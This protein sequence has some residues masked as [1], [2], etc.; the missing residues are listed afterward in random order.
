MNLQK[1]ELPKPTYWPVILAFSITLIA[2]GLIS[3]W[4]ISVAGAVVLVV[5]IIG[6]MREVS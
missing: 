5:S 6:W 4:I 3:G 1:N 2:W